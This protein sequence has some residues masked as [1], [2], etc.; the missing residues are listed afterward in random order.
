MA[1]SLAGAKTLYEE[2]IEGHTQ[3]LGP[4]HTGTL[5]AKMNLANILSDKSDLVGAKSLYEEAI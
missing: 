3:Q 2:V 4:Q 1:T 5:M